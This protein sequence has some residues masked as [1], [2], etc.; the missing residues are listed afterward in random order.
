MNPI[1]DGIV[2][3]RFPPNKICT[4]QSLLLP[5]AEAGLTQ[6]LDLT[7]FSLTKTDGHCFRSQFSKVHLL[8]T[9]HVSS[10]IHFMSFKDWKDSNALPELADKITL[11]ILHDDLLQDT[12]LQKI[13]Q[14]SDVFYTCKTRIVFSCLPN[15]SYLHNHEIIQHL[16]TPRPKVPHSEDLRWIHVAE[17]LYPKLTVYQNINEK[18]LRIL[19]PEFSSLKTSTSFF[20]IIHQPPSIQHS[21][22]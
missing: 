17:E 12:S 4:L 5:L 7:Q 3:L 2:H 16:Q 19:D 9:R 10:P 20:Y 11:I 22:L 18:N 8:H 21:Q 6:Q 14:F 13:I 1:P 15:L